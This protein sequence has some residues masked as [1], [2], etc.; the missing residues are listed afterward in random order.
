MI[1]SAC[2]IRLIAELGSDEPDKDLQTHVET[3]LRE[4]H[5]TVSGQFISFN[6][7]NR[8]F[9]LDLKKTDDFDALIDKRAESLGQ[10]QLDRFLLRSA[11]T[12]YGMSG[13]HLCHRLQDLA[14]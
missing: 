11:Q 2:L 4:I 13:C 7:D 6:A 3:V 9:Y 12:C 14:T 5:K 10:A 8:Q 1:V